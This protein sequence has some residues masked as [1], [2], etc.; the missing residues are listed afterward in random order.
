MQTYCYNII[1]IPSFFTKS[2]LNFS[3]L[4]LSTQWINLFHFPSINQIKEK[5]TQLLFI[6]S[7][8]SSLINKRQM[9]SN[10]KKLNCCCWFARLS[11]WACC[12]AAAQLITHNKKTRMNQQRKIMKRKKKKERRK[13]RQ[14][15]LSLPFSLNLFISFI[16]Q[17]KKESS[18]G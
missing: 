12:P 11:C 8:I 18:A 15:S 16:I 7:S 5:Q 13:T 2:K 14:P 6:L 17:N 10:K 9:N 3:F 1:L 4:L